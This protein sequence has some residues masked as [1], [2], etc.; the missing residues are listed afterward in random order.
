MTQ[1]EIQLLID[2]IVTNAN[3]RANQ[4]NPLLTDMLTAS[5]GP[6]Y[7]DDVPPTNSNDETQGYRLGS[8]GYDTISQ[9]FYICK[10]PAAGAAEWQLIPVDANY[11]W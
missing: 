2:Q 3:Y 11:E 4:L 5:Y 1:A 9:R 7:I 8:I 10:N 6:M